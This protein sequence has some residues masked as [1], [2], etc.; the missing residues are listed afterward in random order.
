M[1]AAVSC[2]R[3][4]T[5]HGDPVRDAKRVYVGT[6]GI[7]GINRVEP[8]FQFLDHIFYDPKRIAVDRFDLDLSA[9]ACGVSDHHPICADFR[10]SR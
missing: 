10:L 7:R 9:E 1:S 6:P 2:R 5:E 4:P 8:K 3:C